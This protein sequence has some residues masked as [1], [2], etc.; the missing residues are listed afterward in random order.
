[1]SPESVDDY[2]LN[3]FFEQK[4]PQ[5]A[6]KRPILTDFL[7]SQAPGSEQAMALPLSQ[8]QADPLFPG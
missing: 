8:P 4:M 7:D 2:L 6:K 5:K 1:V 3:W